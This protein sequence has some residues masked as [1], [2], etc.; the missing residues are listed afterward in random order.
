VA[1]ADRRD[2]L[3]RGVPSRSRNET[4]IARE[5]PS[6]AL[7]LPRLSEMWQQLQ[8]LPTLGTLCEAHWGIR[9]NDGGQRSA[10]HPRPASGRA[11][12]LLNARDH[13]QFAL[14]KVSYLDVRP[15]VVYGAGDL[16]WAEPKILCNAGRSSR[17]NWRIAAAVDREGLV[18]SQQF[19]CLWPLESDV[20]LDALTAVI[21]SP[22]GN[23]YLNEHS[24]DRRLRITTLL[25]LPL[26]S[27][28]PP[29]LG[30]LSRE[31]ARLVASNTLFQ[32]DALQALLDRIDDAVL[33][34]YDLSPRTI[35]ALLSEFRGERRP[36]VHAW[37]DW[38]VTPDSP[39]LTV[40]EL[41][42]EWVRESRGAW[43]A[44]QL[45]PVPEEEM[46]AYLRA[47]G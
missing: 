10:S 1:D 43:P 44:K 30:E 33:E 32:N 19:A 23:A 35:R 45:A 34:A 8:G 46:K 17:G 4:R 11:P 37:L 6:G 26:P 5:T 28:L 42:S 7:W 18:A 15:S 22:L 21:N 24:S 14:G 9:W 2:F 38:D 25:A 13:R 31:Y 3:T 47:V 12:G 36:V 40:R 16:P 27:R 39:A 41:R 29:S 20:D